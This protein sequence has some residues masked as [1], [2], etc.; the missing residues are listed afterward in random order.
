MEENFAVAQKE[1]ERAAKGVH[2]VLPKKTWRDKEQTKKTKKKVARGSA[3][4]EENFGV[5]QKG[6]K[7]A[8]RGAYEELPKKMGRDKV[9]TKKTKKKRHEVHTGK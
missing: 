5:A 9:Q 6:E 8:A 1:R 3:S 2:E 4:V 7:R